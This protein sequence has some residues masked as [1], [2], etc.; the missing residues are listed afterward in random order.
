MDHQEFA[1]LNFFKLGK[2]FGAEDLVPPRT[3][4]FE[5]RMGQV[6]LCGVI[7][8]LHHVCE[9]FSRDSQKFFRV[10]KDV[11]QIEILRLNLPLIR[12]QVASLILRPMVCDTAVMIIFVIVGIT[13]ILAPVKE[14]TAATLSTPLKSG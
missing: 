4:R 13:D 6:D 10:I 5:S 1:E 3:G 8:N 2:A 11:G 14:S 12:C 7:L 9:L